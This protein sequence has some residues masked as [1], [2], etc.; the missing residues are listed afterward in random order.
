[1]NKGFTLIELLAVVAIIL[2]LSLVVAMSV[3][4]IV[5]NS[6]E[7]LSI[8]QK[9]AIEDAT[10]MWMA[11]NVDKIPDTNNTCI[12]I[13]YEDLRDSSY[14]NQILDINT[15]EELDDDLAITIRSIETNGNVKYSYEVDPESTT[16]CTPAV[17]HT[18]TVYNP[19]DLVRYDPVSNKPCTSGATCYKW[20]VITVGDTSSDKKITLQMDHNLVNT[21][22]WVS[23]ADYNDDTNYGTYG[24]TDKGPIT[25][26]KALETATANWHKSLR[27]T[28]SYDTRAATKNYGLLSCS[29]GKCTIGNKVVTSNQ[30]ARII[31]AEEVAALTVA[32]GA[33]EGTTAYNWTISN[34][35]STFYFSN[36]GYTIGTYTGV[37]NHSGNTTLSWLLENTDDYYR[38]TTGATDNTYGAVNYGYWTLSMSNNS[39]EYAY[40]VDHS[41]KVQSTNVSSTGSGIRPVIT[42]SKNLCGIPIDHQTTTNTVYTPGQL[43]QYD[44]VNNKAC[45]SG[46][47]CYKWRVITADDSSIYTT[48]TLQMDHNLVNKSAWVSKSDYND[49]TNYGTNGKIDKGPITALKALETA[50]ANWNGVLEL[51]YYYSTNNETLSINNYKKLTCVNGACTING[52]SVTSNLKARM[53]TGE[54][55]TKLIVAAGAASGSNAGSWNVLRSN[56]YWY[57]FSNKNYIIGTRNSA[58]NQT[59]STSLSWLVE[60]TTAN[61]NSGATSNTFGNDNSG[62]WTL[63]PTSYS[64]YLAW[65]VGSVGEFKTSAVNISENYGI[66]PVITIPKSI[67]AS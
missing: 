19:G 61:A 12:Y 22:A 31:T 33:A 24:R 55:V 5:K 15:M 1:M 67:F 2:T 17:T 44:P 49:N 28:Y 35:A 6:K 26:F 25:V 53:I 46:T 9:Q 23:K 20:R 52:Q 18:Y 39:N 64:T 50:T 38:E 16:G 60:N 40:I 8:T 14:I 56:G 57:Y 29:K 7:K 47:T 42:I 45:I 36:T 43:L 11:D 34:G 37:G 21:V 59:G 51:N 41:G 32:A 54:E 13:T 10:G 65:Y 62:Y 63:S 58:S 30:K 3:S 4:T 27:L 66:R 48:I